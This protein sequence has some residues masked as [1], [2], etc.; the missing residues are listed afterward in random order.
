MMKTLLIT[1]GS[2]GI[3]EAI[4]KKY[5]TKEYR[6]INLDIKEP[7]PIENEHYEFIPCDISDT[8]ALT[9]VLRTLK[10]IDI[11]I[12]NAAQFD[13]S[14]FLDQPIDEIKEIL[15]TNII[16]H[17][18]IA[19]HYAREF[20]GDNGCIIIITST[21]ANMSEEDTIGYTLSKGALSSLVHGLAVTLR[22][23]NITVNGIAPGWIN[24]HNDSLRDVDHNFHLSGRVG[25][26][27]D[28]VRACEYLTHKDNNF[29]NG[30]IITI[31][32]GVTKTMIYPE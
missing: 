20:Q 28:I 9:A 2:Q 7:E 17:V 22:H 26:N 10:H 4:V 3:G 18:Q 13:H 8:Q 23:K 30:E 31:D 12:L 27:N 16:G 32:G 15:N 25:K 14:P 21:R 19:Q 5:L 24:S 11:L 1:G 6:V 29:I